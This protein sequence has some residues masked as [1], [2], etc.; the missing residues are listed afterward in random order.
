MSQENLE[1][2]LRTTVQDRYSE[3]AESFEA[4]TRADCGCQTTTSC[5]GDEADRG[6]EIV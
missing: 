2:N 5:C 4:G 3:I 1:L 6:G